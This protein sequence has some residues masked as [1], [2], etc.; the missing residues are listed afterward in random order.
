MKLG[1]VTFLFIWLIVFITG[2]AV[3]VP[4][5]IGDE[6]KGVTIQ[7]VVAGFTFI[8]LTSKFVDHVLNGEMNSVYIILYVITI[9]L[10]LVALTGVYYWIPQYFPEGIDDPTTGKKNTQLLRMILV[11]CFTMLMIFINI[12]EREYS[13]SICRCASNITN[14]FTK[15]TGGKK[16]KK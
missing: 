5:Y 2:L 4:S 10:L 13:E 6:Y 12:Y 8:A 16:L 9:G 1:L 11:S 14:A 3:W 7:F 15:L